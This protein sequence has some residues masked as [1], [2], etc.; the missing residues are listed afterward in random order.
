MVAAI[1]DIL[2]KVKSDDKITLAFLPKGATK[3][4]VN[5]LRINVID[6]N[7]VETAFSGVWMNR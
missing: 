4:D 7:N 2:Y 6:A 3:S 1:T 5:N